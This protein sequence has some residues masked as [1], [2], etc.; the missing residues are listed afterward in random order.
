MSATDFHELTDEEAAA[1]RH[2]GPDHNNPPEH[3]RPETI[4]QRL[5]KLFKPMVDR[6]AGIEAEAANMPDVIEDDETSKAIGDLVKIAKTELRAA[7]AA[8]KAEKDPYKAAGDQ[9]DGFFKVKADRVKSVVAALEQRVSSY[10]QVKAQ[11]EARRRQEEADRLRAE[12]EA[13]MREAEEAD[14]RRAEAEAAALNER[15]TAD[16]ARVGL[17]VAL[18]LA[19]DARVERTLAESEMRDAK[20]ANDPDAYTTASKRRDDAHAKATALEARVK[21]LRAQ[22]AAA[23]ER[24]R[25]QERAAKAERKAAD[26]AIGQAVVHGTASTRHEKAATASAADLSRTRGDLGSVAS[27]RTDWVFDNLERTNIDLEALRQH[28][29]LTAIEQA[30]RSWINAN[31]DGLKSGEAKLRGVRVFEQTKAVVR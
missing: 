10:L 4:A 22:E 9:V 26:D 6:L 30:V 13:R 14:A 15:A 29:P 21:E 19:S 12:A 28:L 18:G 2:I 24:A 1:L 8:R 17:D 27:L 3:L 23:N 31:K 20:R 16:A 5:T 25:E 7:E 11:R